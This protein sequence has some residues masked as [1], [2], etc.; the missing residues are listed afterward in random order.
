MP[1]NL[2]ALI[3]TD[4]KYNNTTKGENKELVEMAAEQFAMLFYKQWKHERERKIRTSKD[5]DKYG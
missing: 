5:T 4:S 3:S 2:N 1:E